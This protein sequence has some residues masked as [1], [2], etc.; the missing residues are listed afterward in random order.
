MKITE[1]KLRK[2]INSVILE[3]ASP[4]S[5]G[6]R[7]KLKESDYESFSQKHLQSNNKKASLDYGDHFYYE[8]FEKIS[9]H[10]HEMGAEDLFDDHEK[11]IVDIAEEIAG[12]FAFLLQARK[13]FVT[14][15][16]KMNKVIEDIEEIEQS[17]ENGS[18][19][20]MFDDYDKQSPVSTSSKGYDLACIISD[21]RDD[22]IQLITGLSNT[23]I[24]NL[25]QFVKKSDYDR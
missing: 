12:Q 24:T 10:L 3:T 21:I 1:S 11:E 20:Q 4:T 9:E 14:A 6:K 15:I 25:K 18:L 8:I 5:K 23:Q 2:I 13:G 19:A 16:V 7:N 17:L 22:Y